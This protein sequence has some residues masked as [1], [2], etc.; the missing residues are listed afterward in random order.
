MIGLLENNG[1]H[2]ISALFSLFIRCPFGSAAKSSCPF[3]KFRR[4]KNLEEKY[5]LAENFS[6]RQRHRL[7]SK[8]RDCYQ[9]KING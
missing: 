7:L 4:L 2:E 1:M 3:H 9:G 8:H 5:Y 6:R